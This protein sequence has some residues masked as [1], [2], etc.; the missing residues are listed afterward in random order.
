MSLFK[1]LFGG[2]KEE[3]PAKKGTK[4]ATSAVL[5]IKQ[6]DRLTADA[7]KV[8]FEVPE[9]LK[10]SYSYIPGQYLNV[11][12]EVNGEKVPRSYSICSDVS[13]PLAIGIKK[14]EK[15]LVST[16]FNDVAKAG[17]EIEVGFPLG[18]FQMTKVEGNYVAIAA[19]SGIT[20]VLSIAK[21]VNR[22]SEGHLELFYGNRND[23]SI[24]FEDEL[25]ALSTDKV[26]TTHIFSEQEKEGFLHGMLT[27][28]VITDIIKSN[29]EILKAKGF[30][31]CGPEPVII[32]AQ[33]AL[34][35]FGVAEEKMFYELFTTPVLM[36]STA[37][38]VVSSF[39]GISKVTVI[40][41]DEEEHFEL[42]SDGDT[43]LEEA[44]SHGIDAPYSCRGAICCTCKAKVLKGSAT[45][46]KNFTLTDKE[47]KEGYILTCQAHPN[48]EELIVSYDE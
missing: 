4:E 42:A 25:N 6:I 36:E 19:G 44:E 13:E 21:L 35:K 11:I 28:E 30:Y 20:P 47:I 27:E 32:N 10:E 37:E 34:K 5:K 39:S 31:L 46:E 15:G 38:A 16:H 43:I 29:L 22:T 23:Q 12:V 48:S 26:K 8:V 3:T 41:D 18:N 2:K 1:K 9:A 14:V 45:M 24:M 40:L 7:V 17:D 33:N